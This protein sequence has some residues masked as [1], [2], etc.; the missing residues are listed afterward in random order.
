MFMYPVYCHNWR[1]INVIYVCNKISIKRNIRT[2][3]IHREIGRAKDLSAPLYMSLCHSLIVS[4]E[5]A[6]TSRKCCGG[7]VVTQT[8]CYRY[9]NLDAGVLLPPG[10]TD[11]E[12]IYGF[13][14]W[15][16]LQAKSMT[17]Q[18]A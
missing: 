1:N 8:G 9:N 2:I 18:R 4:V 3:K 10:H 17:S 11:A 16:G 7:L 15:G 12:Y 14:R 5:F 6:Q 13:V